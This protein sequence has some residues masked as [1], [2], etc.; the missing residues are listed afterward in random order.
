M[1]MT[2]ELFD[3]L[4]LVRTASSGS[5]KGQNGKLL[6]IGGSELFH[7]AS[8]WSLQV[9]ARI[10]DMVFYSSVPENNELIKEAKRFFWD[11]MVVPR[12]ELLSYLE[13]ADCVLIGPGM[14]RQ[15]PI[16]PKR[17]R[18]QWESMSQ[19]D[20]HWNESTWEITNW[21]LA[22]YPQKRWVLDAG[23]LQMVDSDLFTASMIITPHKGEFSQLFGE[24]CT[25]EHA[26]AQSPAHNNLTI[27]A[28]GERDLVVQGDKFLA[29]SGGN[30]GMTKGG[31]GDVLAGL[32]AALYCKNSAWISAVSGSFFCKSAGDALFKEKGTFYTTSELAEEI[33]RTM[34]TVLREIQASR[35]EF[36][37]DSFLD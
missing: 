17:S 10:V 14:T 31:S 12:T 34:H 33:P 19:E 16:P 5:H 2:S 1:Q 21:L 29:V 20:V 11:G 4:E 8:A 3:V 23:A 35:T 32:V 18:E 27:L 26:R 25:E 30:A 9:A 15:S 13:E 36:S 7:A 24:T 22:H 28:K 6:I 37:R